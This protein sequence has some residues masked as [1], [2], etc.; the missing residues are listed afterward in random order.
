LD[1]LE[2]AFALLSARHIVTQLIV[3]SEPVD[4][5]VTFGDGVSYVNYQEFVSGGVSGCKTFYSIVCSKYQIE[6]E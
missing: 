3:F 6:C 1:F 2:L 5:D 4:G